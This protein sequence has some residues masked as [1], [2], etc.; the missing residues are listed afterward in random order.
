MVICVLETAILHHVTSERRVRIG[1]LADYTVSPKELDAYFRS[2]TEWQALPPLEAGEQTSDRQFLVTFD[3]GYRNNLTAALPVLEAHDVSCLLFVTTGFIDGTVYPY[4]LELAEAVERSET[5]RIPRRR[6]PVVLGTISE[7]RDLYRDLR[8]PLK[9]AS[10]EE[11]GAFMEQLAEENGYDRSEM[12]SEPL[13]SWEEV[14]TLS[15]HPLVTIGAHTRLHTLLSQQPW[16]VALEEMRTS[17]QR[18]E[19]QIGR[20]V[21]AVSYP[22]GG[23][24]LIIRHMARWVG[25][26]YGFTTEARRV[27]RVT[28]W[29][30]LA[31][32]RIDV[33]DL[34][35]NDE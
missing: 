10:H 30:R 33:S 23:S 26:D 9:T 27:D 8:L 29:N 31:L 13:L 12:Q 2:R 24:N 1:P 32:P 17:K 21:S 7:R 28:A 5:L 4:E 25:F 18:L 14:R 20:S 6:E 11:R 19:E 35:P 15:D 34:V 16:R 22:Y 3:D